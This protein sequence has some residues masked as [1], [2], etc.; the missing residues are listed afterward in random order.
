[1]MNT[2]ILRGGKF[3]ELT[4]DEHIKYRHLIKPENGSGYTFND[5]AGDDKDIKDDVEF[6]IFLLENQC[7]CKLVRIFIVQEYHVSR[8]MYVYREKYNIYSHNPKDHTYRSFDIPKHCYDAS[9]YKV[10]MDHDNGHDVVIID[11]C[12]MNERLMKQIVKLEKKK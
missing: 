12:K 1:M 10:D 5:V 6:P 8:V 11:Y 4:E 3:V 7:R 2:C 9:E